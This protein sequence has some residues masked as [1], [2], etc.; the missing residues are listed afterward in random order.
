MWRAENQ[1]RP[2]AWGVPPMRSSSMTDRSGVAIWFV[3]LALCHIA[4]ATAQ[5]AEKL[6]IGY[7]EIAD[8][9]RYAPIRGAERMIIATRDRPF[10]AVEVALD[11][12]R[13]LGRVIHREFSVARIT[14]RTVQDVAP[15]VLDSL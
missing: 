1:R 15:A 2:C 8:D 13:P 11:E 3:L 9:E 7:I 12:A 5:T 10:P 4:F 14:V 6:T